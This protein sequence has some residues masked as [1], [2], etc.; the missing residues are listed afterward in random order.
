MVK[1]K[2][3]ILAKHFVDEPKESD[4]QLVEDDL[5]ALKDREI[6]CEAVWLSVDPY[7]RPYSNRFPTGVTMIGTQ[8][9]KVVE[10]R[11]P[12]YEVGIH[13]VGHFGWQTKTVVNADNPGTWLWL[14]KPYIIPDFSG[15]SLSLALG[16]LG[17][18]GNTAY[19]G[20]LEICDP[21]PGEVVVVSGAAGAVGS[22]VGQIARIK[23][24]KVIGFT[25]SDEKVKW[26]L[27]ELK[28]DAAFNYKAIDI[29]KAI[30]QAAPDGVDCYFDNV[31]GALSSAVIS[32][33]KNRGRISV[34]GSISAYN[35]DINKLP[36][37]PTV[38]PLLLRKELKME[39]FMVSRWHNRWDE[40]VEQNLQWIKETVSDTYKKKH[41]G[42][43]LFRHQSRGRKWAWDGHN[44]SRRT[45]GRAVV[46]W[47]QTARQN[48]GRS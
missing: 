43:E 11:H 2:K 1:T 48:S 32:Q 30:Q 25:G 46:E 4:L 12:D 22:H 17:M 44:S 3:F 47:R 5:P 27:N 41:N 31:G 26:L 9:A 24:C 42:R 8:V 45:R 36:S 13:V 35:A 20:F 23:G 29:V 14:K 16:V 21:K 6:L 39:G 37:A 7:M 18:P 19:F 34:C 28:F 10:S 40:G 15:L 33:M 38:L